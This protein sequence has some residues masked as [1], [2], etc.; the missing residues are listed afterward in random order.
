MRES[1]LLRHIEKRS[2]DLAGRGAVVVGPGDDAAVLNLDAGTLV[3]VDQ[4]VAGRHFDPGAATID[5]IA[6]KAVARSVSDIA[7]MG[8]RPTCA[9]ATGCLPSGFAAGDELFDR[10]AQ[11]GRHWGCPLV[12]G[13]IAMSDGPMVLTVT[14]IGR[15][16]ERRGAVLRSSAR[17]GDA[18][19]ATGAFGGS[20]ESGRHLSFEPRV[21]EGGWLCDALGDALHAMIDVSDGLGRDAGRVARAAGVRVVIEADALPL[22]PGVS[23]WREGASDGEDYELMFTVES[24]AAVPK[25]CPASGVSIT[26]IGTVTD[27]AGDSGGSGCFIRTPDNQLHAAEELGWDHTS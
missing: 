20:L 27:A 12:G 11:W 9:L 18:V 23:S 6:R 8:G 25:S 21:A 5:Q 22:H 24:G 17:A 1:E 2:R 10:M 13:D 15:A 7:A 14:V 19:Y 16:H 3:T 26:R 4:L